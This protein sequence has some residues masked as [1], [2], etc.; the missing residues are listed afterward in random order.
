V[1]S[2]V[3]RPTLWPVRERLELCVSQVDCGRRHILLEVRDR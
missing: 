1:T 2:A 3:N